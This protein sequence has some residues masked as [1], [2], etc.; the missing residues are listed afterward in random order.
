[1]DPVLQKLNKYLFQRPG[2][3]AFSVPAYF[4]FY[5]MKELNKTPKKINKV[6]TSSHGSSNKENKK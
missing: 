5:T 1:M 3:R 6:P 2:S 4:P